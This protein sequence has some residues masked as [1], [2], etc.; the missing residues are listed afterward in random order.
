MKEE[1]GIVWNVKIPQTLYTKHQSKVFGIEA[2]DL[3][4]RAGQWPR[5]VMYEGRMFAY[6]RTYS[7]NEGDIQYLA[8]R[9]AMTGDQLNV[10]ND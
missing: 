8:Y 2:S 1:N 6:V 4:L 7:D 9:D 10:W 3:G 5:T